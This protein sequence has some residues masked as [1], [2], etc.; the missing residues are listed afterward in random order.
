VMATIRSRGQ[1]T[2][3]LETVL[4]PSD[5]ASD[6]YG[7]TDPDDLAWMRPRLTPHPWKTFEQPI[8]LTNQSALDRLPRAH[9]LQHDVAQAR[10]GI[11]AAGH[12][13]RP[14]VGDRH[15]SRSDDHRAG[16]GG[17]NAP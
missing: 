12:N 13:G 15:R 9:Q 6:S 5:P 8:R 7:V 2:G 14:C 17:A 4:L 11:P 10:V 16:S 1:V 3:G